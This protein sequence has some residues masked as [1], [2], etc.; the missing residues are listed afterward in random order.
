MADLQKTFSA[1]RVGAS[2]SGRFRRWKVRNFE[3]VVT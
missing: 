2:V 3:S 1:M